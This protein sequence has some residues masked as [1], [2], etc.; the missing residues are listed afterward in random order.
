VIITEQYPKG[1]GTTFCG[2]KD[3]LSEK[4][5]YYEKTSFNALEDK[6]IIGN[7]EELSK[8]N[9]VVFGIE[10]HICVHQ[11]VAALIE[12]GYNVTVIKDACGSRS[13]NEYSDGLRIMELNG[14]A[15]KTTE[16]VLFELIKGAK[17]PHFKEIQALIK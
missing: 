14:A 10:T 17:H 15:V 6:N 5:R 3:F 11:T 7:L 13:E 8:K 2:I 9:I 12:K 1:L 4:C 16:M